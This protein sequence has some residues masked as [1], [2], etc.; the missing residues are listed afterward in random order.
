[1][2]KNIWPRRVNDYIV[3]E[4]LPRGCLQL[5]WN[6]VITKDLKDLSIDNYAKGQLCQE[7]YNAKSVTHQRWTSTINDG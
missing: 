4:V 6:D 3:P 1:M 2:H 7:K 5:C